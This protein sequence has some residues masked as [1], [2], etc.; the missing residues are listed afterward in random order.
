MSGRV[1]SIAEHAVATGEVPGVVAALGT[2]DAADVGVA[3]FA[4]LDGPPIR[5]DSVFR[6][7]SVTKPIVAAATLVL[8]ERGVLNLA[9]PVTRWLPELAAPRVLRHPAADLD[10]TVPATS[11]ILVR[12]LPALQGGLGLTADFST[13]L[14]TAILERLHQGPPDPSAMPGPDRWVAAAAELPLVH[15]PGAGWTYNTG[16]DLLGVLLARAAGCSLTQVLQDTLGEP[17]GWRDTR[18]TADRHQLPRLTAASRA[19]EGGALTCVDPPDGAWAGPVPFE[20]GGGGLLSTLDDLLAFGTM[21]GD[22]GRRQGR[23]VLT[24]ES[25][26][27][28]TTPT[29]RSEPDD[30]FLAGQAWALGGSVDVREL[31]PWEAPGRYGW[32]GGTGTA[33]YVYPSGQVAIWLTQ[34][35]MA[36]PADGDRLIPLLALAAEA[37]QAG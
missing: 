26:R 31:N 16:F 24:A 21:L 14:A 25:V 20:S 18:F 17:L 6:V 23:P 12:H 15:Q 35:E 13:P 37:E 7:A 30:I 3:G 9:D 33:L 29:H 4:A 1:Q 8:A 32:A 28:L 22:H 27:L 34:R 19:D 36:G 11:P 10:D 2:G 5:R